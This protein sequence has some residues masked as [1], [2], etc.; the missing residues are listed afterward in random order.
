MIDVPMISIAFL[1][2]GGPFLDDQWQAEPHEKAG[3]IYLGST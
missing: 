1:P 3:S 2:V